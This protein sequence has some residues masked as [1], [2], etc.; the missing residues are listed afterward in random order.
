[1]ESIN[2]VRLVDPDSF[3]RGWF[4]TKVFELK[5]KPFGIVTL[6]P[7][8]VTVSTELSPRIVL[9]LTVRPESTITLPVGVTVRLPFAATINSTAELVLLDSL[10]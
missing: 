2:W 4:K 1:M 9:P 5:F 3:I 8:N 7:V 10:S 6:V